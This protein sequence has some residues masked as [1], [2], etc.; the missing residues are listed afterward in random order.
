LFG[1]RRRDPAGH[2]L[3]IRRSLKVIRVSD[4]AGDLRGLIMAR[5]VRYHCRILEGCALG[6]AFL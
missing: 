3:A 5:A 6:S 2:R 1:A 4:A